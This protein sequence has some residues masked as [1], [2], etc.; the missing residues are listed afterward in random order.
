MKE[1]YFGG[2]CFW[3][4]EK[5]L[6]LIPG[7]T[8]TE[9]GYANGHTTNPTYKEVCEEE[10]GHVE[11]VKVR[12]NPSQVSLTFLLDLFFDSIDP[13][14]LNKQGGDEGTQYRSGVYYC[15]NSD[16]ELIHQGINQLQKQYSKP[17]VIE[18]LPL[19]S[20]YLAEEYHQKYLDK[21]PTGYCHIG[22]NMFAKAKAAVDPYLS[23]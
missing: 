15:D 6:S 9:V 10:T 19:S 14:T 16:L 4:V 2:G 17:I 5:Y 13:T 21:N 20:F 11:A 23:N 7:V 3:G 12:Y 22:E 18:V 8:H 1:I